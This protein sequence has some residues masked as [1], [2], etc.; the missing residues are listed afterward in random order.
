MSVSWPKYSG[1]LLGHKLSEPVLW[2][3]SSLRSL[4]IIRDSFLSNGL[5]VHRLQ[6]SHLP[7]FFPHFASNVRL[8][9]PVMSSK[10]GG[11]AKPLKQPKADKKEYDEHDMANLQKKKDEEKALKELRAKASQKGSFGGSGLK[12]SGKK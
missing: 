9:R 12:K 7:F 2:V 5:Q 8:Y 6:L 11:K 10:Q 3:A 4:Y 1:L